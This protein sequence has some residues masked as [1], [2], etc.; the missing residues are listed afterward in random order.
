MAIAKCE[1]LL[2]PT[3]ESVGP[4]AAAILEGREQLVDPLRPTAEFVAIGAVD[5]PAH[6]EVLRHGH[7]TEDAFASRQ[8]VDAEPGALLGRGVGDVPAVQP[9]H[10][11]GGDLQ[12]RQR[13]SSAVD[14]PAPLV[15]R[16]ASTSP[17]FTSK[18]TPKRICTWP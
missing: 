8:Q 15:P 4:F 10:A 9:Y 3:G 12:A 16:S 17:R 6:L 11:T 14:F 2:L 18:L 7:R 5:E 1:H 13:H